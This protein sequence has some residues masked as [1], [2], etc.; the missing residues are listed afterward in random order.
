MSLTSCATKTQSLSY[1]EG[2][3][4]TGIEAAVFYEEKLAENEAIELRYNYCYS[5]FEGEDYQHC[6]EEAKVAESLYPN[7]IRFLYLQVL[8]AEMIKDSETYLK[9]L[10]NVQQQNPVDK[11]ILHRLLTYYQE[12]QESEEAETIAKTLLHL[13]KKDEAAI[14]YFA[15]HSDFY[16]YLESAEK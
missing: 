7:Y 15:Q 10:L 14:S 11:E 16:R 5:L 13:D 9:A 1:S 6:L 8:S 12:H 3:Q 2:Y 4:L